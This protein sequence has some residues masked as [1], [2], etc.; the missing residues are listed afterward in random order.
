MKF[1]SL[2]QWLTLFVFILLCTTAAYAQ[3]RSGQATTNA[4]SSKLSEMKIIPYNGASD[5][6]SDNI[7]GTDTALFN[8]LD[9]SLLVK[10]EVTGK[11]GEF[12]DRSVEITARQGNKVVLSK[13]AM[14]GIFNESGKYYVTAWIYNPVCQDTIIQARLLGQKQPSVIKKTVTANCGE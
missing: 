9:T 3:R 11:A 13:T 1:A 12:S 5:T 6:F 8:D 4:A 2:K 14:V 7:V 10:V